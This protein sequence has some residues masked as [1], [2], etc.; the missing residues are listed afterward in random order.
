MEKQ[1]KTSVSSAKDVFS[2]LLMIGML[3]TSVISFITLL[4]QYINV[5]FPDY[6]EFY[7]T[8]ATNII[9]ISMS[10]LI[11]A[12]PVLLLVS[13]MI[14]K[15][16]KKDVQKSNVWIRKWML[17]LTIFVA[18]ITIIV[19]L[20]T[21]VDHFL[22]GEITIRFG[23]KV[24]VVLIVA[25]LVF[26]YELW[27]LKRDTSAK[28]RLPLISAI[29]GS[30]L[31]LGWVISGFF[32]VGSPTTQRNIRMDQQRI[33]DLQI[34]QSRLLEQWTQK[35]ELPKV[36]SDLED[37]IYGFVEPIDPE[38]KEQYTYTL[39]DELSFELCATFNQKSD[40]GIKNDRTSMITPYFYGVTDSSM[41]FWDHEVGYTCFERTIDPDL[42][43]TEAI[44][45]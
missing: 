17:H 1:N 41:D 20:I 37:P 19:D 25:A 36:L 44:V 38:T 13:W 6:L 9:R 14:I 43:H 11:I 42:Y 21:L 23:L 29:I 16:L 2:Y 26:G 27:D 40:A 39:K 34:I 28:S 18:A 30:V 8:N 45:K 35:G 15:D 22:G 5:Q 3:Y 7:Y 10:A 33:S 24:A 12:W 31:I 32:I 4:S